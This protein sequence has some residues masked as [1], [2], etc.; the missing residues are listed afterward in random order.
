[1]LSPYTRVILKGNLFNT[2][3]QLVSIADLKHMSNS[4]TFHHDFCYCPV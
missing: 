3:T 4:I 1:M 2:L